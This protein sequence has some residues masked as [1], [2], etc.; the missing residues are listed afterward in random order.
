MNRREFL[1]AS[2]GIAAMVAT[3]R[4]SLGE[5][6]KNRKLNVLLIT[7]DDMNY[8]APGF[9]GGRTPGLTPN[10]DRL[11]KES[12]YFKRAHVAAAICQPSRQSMMTGLYP[13]NNGALGFGPINSGVATLQERLRGAGY[14]N[15]ILGKVNHLAPRE[16]F[17][18]D[19]VK[20]QKE[21]GE[22]R[23]P[24]LYYRYVKEF[25][26]KAQAEGKPF[27]LMANSH[28]PHRPFAGSVAEKQ[29]ETRR[30]IPHPEVRR[31]F[32]PDKIAVPGFL[33]DLPGVRK[34]VAEYYTSAHRCDETIG[35]VLRALKESGQEE[36]TLVMFLS[37]NGMSFPFAKANCYLSSTNTPWLVRW[38]GKT[39]PGSVDEAHFICGVDFMPTILDACGLE[40]PAGLDGRSFAGL[41]TG[42]KQDGRESVFTVINTLATRKSY[43]MRCL[44]NQ[45]FGYIYN[46]WSDGQAAYYTTESRGSLAFR[47]MQEAAKTDPRIAGRVE[48]FEHRV[49]EELYDFEK[50]PSALTN[51]VDDPAYKEALAQMRRAMRDAMTRTKDPVIRKFGF[52][53]PATQP[54]G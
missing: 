40:P 14:V 19:Y 53:P 5:P 22:G 30:K 11:A 16:K 45:R 13:H 9:A 2:A 27:F 26:A 4:L 43:P 3:W 6:V 42:D 1:R 47:A 29:W 49:K 46:A 52:S 28:D 24:A 33:P 48:L 41:L 17:C 50:D 8:D 25:L 35:Q 7:A 32:K 39:K 54:G 36:E 44:Q 37:D 23:D 21:L 38:P 10:L 18:W 20:E 51:L 12:L 31:T 15:G 34:E